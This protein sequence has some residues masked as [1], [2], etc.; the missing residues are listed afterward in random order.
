M[1]VVDAR[2]LKVA[3]DDHVDGLG[4]EAVHKHV[5]A[6][7]V[8]ALFEGRVADLHGQGP[9]DADEGG[10]HGVVLEVRH[11]H[12]LVQLD[13]HALGDL[14]EQ[15]DVALLDARP[16]L[17]VVLFHE[18]VDLDGQLAV[19]LPRTYEVVDAGL[20][21]DPLHV[22]RPQLVYGVGDAADEGGEDNHRK[23]HHGYGEEALR[24]VLR[25]DVVRGGRELRQGPVKRSEVLE[26]EACVVEV[27]L[28]DPSALVGLIEEADGVPHARDVVVQRQDAQNH[29]CDL[30]GKDKGATV[31]PVQHVVLDLLQ[32]YDP[33]QPHE[34]HEAQE[35][36]EA[37]LAVLI[38]VGRPNLD[39]KKG[40]I[41]CENRHVRQEPR[42]HVPL[43]HGAGPELHHSIDLFPDE[44]AREE[45]HEP[46]D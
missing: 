28:D 18:A 34:A 27:E 3:G 44:E 35:L 31:E 12:L 26:L 21:S 19:D 42:A 7:Q 30:E 15:G 37:H 2:V 10:E 24:K 1:V 5:L 41:H 29:A 43:G 39:E 4:L 6:R 23:Q 36:G 8:R 32:L 25:G 45:I 20:V 11:V 13:P 17:F 9:V 14:R 46:E 38:L 33:N 40:A 16:A 22:D